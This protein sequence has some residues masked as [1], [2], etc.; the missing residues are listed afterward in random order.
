MESWENKILADKLNSLQDFP[1]G[2]TP[3]LSAKWEI[4]ETGLPTG[5]KRRVPL[6]VRWSVAA[7]VL[8]AVGFVW[9]N[10]SREGQVGVAAIQN[11]VSP[12]FLLNQQVVENRLLPDNKES[13]SLAYHP[14]SKTTTIPVCRDTK[15]SNEELA[16]QLPPK[17]VAIPVREDTNRGSEPMFSA[18]DAI[19]KQDTV[20]ASPE[21]VL[22][23]I[24]P[25]EKP[26]AAKKRIYQRDFND[27][28]LTTDTGF[29]PSTRQHFSI[30]LTPFNRKTNDDEPPARRLQLK[31]AL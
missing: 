11:I 24:T 7:A 28:V 26:K 21:T 29:S 10:T 9:M 30:K 23:S 15:Q 5:K 18:P 19:I 2:Y 8:L 6:L 17:T 25:V 1:A 31:Q 14:L 13:Q 20:A 4:V 22:A 12:T 27:G 16:Y 3:N